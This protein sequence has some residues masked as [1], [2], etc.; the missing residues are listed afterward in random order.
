[1]SVCCVSRRDSGD[2]PV[3]GF[4]LGGD[5]GAPRLSRAAA[6]SWRLRHQ[7]SH[8]AAHVRLCRG[9][10]HPVSVRSLTTG[11]RVPPP[12]IRG[13][14]LLVFGRMAAILHQSGAP[15]GHAHSGRRQQ[16]AEQLGGHQHSHSNASVRAA[17]I[18]AVGDLVQS[19][20]VLMAAVIIHIWVSER[21]KTK[22]KLKSTLRC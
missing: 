17:F 16:R 13:C 21:K 10:Q 4:R 14:D 8:Y 2:A 1:M 11:R 19:V 6:H 9:R 12:V 22:Q 20:G 18:H 3:G 7:Q 5:G 15:H